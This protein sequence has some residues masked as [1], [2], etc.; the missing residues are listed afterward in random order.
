M[1]QREVEII[2][3]LGLHARAA[4]HLDQAGVAL[5]DDH[6]GP[7]RRT[8]GGQ[9]R[10]AG[11][12]GGVTGEGQLV[13][14]GEYPYPVIGAFGRGWDGLEYTSDEFVNIAQQNSNANRRIIVS[15]QEDFFRDFETNHGAGLETFAAS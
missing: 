9:P 11:A 14:G 10:V 12:E 5:L 2:N 13:L 8:A 4:A 15:N 3:K 1:L 6:V 7:R